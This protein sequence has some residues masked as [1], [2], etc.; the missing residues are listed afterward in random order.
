MLKCQLQNAVMHMPNMSTPDKYEYGDAASQAQACHL[1]LFGPV[2]S[3]LVKGT[4]Q[5]VSTGR[6]HT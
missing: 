4:A 2:N 1:A 5:K 6:H 3:G